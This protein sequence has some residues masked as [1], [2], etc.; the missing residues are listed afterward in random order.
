MEYD[1]EREREIKLVVSKGRVEEGIY[2]REI[3]RDQKG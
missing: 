2:G 1:V 3:Y